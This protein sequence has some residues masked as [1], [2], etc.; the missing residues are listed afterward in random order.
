MFQDSSS[1]LAQ[2]MDTLF[3]KNLSHRSGYADA[4]EHEVITND[5]ELWIEVALESL[6]DARAGPASAAA[7]KPEAGGFG[8]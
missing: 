5:K 2:K 8:T 6:C 7:A 3:R 1:A 4:F